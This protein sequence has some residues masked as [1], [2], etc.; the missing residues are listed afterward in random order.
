MVPASTHCTCDFEKKGNPALSPDQIGPVDAVLLSHDQHSD[1]LDNA[2]RA[3]LQNAKRVLTTKAAAGRWKARPRLRPWETA[4]ILHETAA[5]SKSRRR[6]P[7]MGR[8][9]EP[10]S[11]DVVGFV[12]SSETHAFEPL[13]IT[14]DTVWF[15]GVAEVRR[16]FEPRLVLLFCGA[17]QT[18]ASSISP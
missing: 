15:D 11:G 8:G 3:F 2:G 10:L 14:G 4:E 17:A 7:G 18:R 16:R 5:T 12:V 6:R 9:I 13:Y 1:N